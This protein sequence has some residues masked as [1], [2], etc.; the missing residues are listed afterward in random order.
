MYFSY[1]R[2]LINQSS[3][4]INKQSIIFFTDPILTARVKRSL[5]F[6]DSSCFGFYEIDLKVRMVLFMMKI[7]LL[8]FFCCKETF[9]LLLLMTRKQ[10]NIVIQK[11][12]LSGCNEV[13]LKMNSAVCRVLT[14]TFK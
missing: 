13:R 6:N 12:S 9:P 14:L 11:N 10:Q 2:M 8:M 1:Y 4:Q 5:T 3:K 7:S